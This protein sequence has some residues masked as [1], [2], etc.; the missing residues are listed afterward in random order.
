MIILIAYISGILGIIASIIEILQFF[1][2]LKDKHKTSILILIAV[3]TTICFVIYYNID[4]R[5]EI[6]NIRKLKH[7]ILID[8]AKKTS[9]AIIITG[10][11]DNGDYLGYLAQITSF[12]DRH[13]DKY[14][15]E[16]EIYTKILESW[17]KLFEENRKNNNYSN[18]NIDISELKGLVNS[19]QDQLEAICK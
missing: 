16:C 6:E 8:D 19:G 3:S 14:K 9:A 4:K 2:L 12:Y 11:E 17:R 18:Y 15:I 10:W 13:Q 7:Q 1:K 5:N